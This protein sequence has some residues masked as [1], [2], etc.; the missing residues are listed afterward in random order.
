MT[1]DITLVK[2][3][4]EQTTP[5]DQTDMYQLLAAWNTS[6]E[7]ALEAGAIRV[8][9]M[10]HQYFEDVLSLTDATA[11]SSESE[12]H[13]EFLADCCEAYPSGTGDHFCSSILVNIVGRCVIQCRIKNGVEAIPPWALEYLTAVSTKNDGIKNELEASTVGWGIGHP[14]VAVGQKTI[15]RAAAGENDWAMAVLE[16]AVYADPDAGISL[17]EQL[18]REPEVDRP[19]QFL[20]PLDMGWQQSRP[21]LPDFWE[22]ADSYEWEIEFSQTQRN[23]ILDILRDVVPA[24]R[25]R[26]ADHAFTF[27]LK[28]VAETME[29]DQFPESVPDAMVHLG[30]HEGGKWHL[31]GDVGCPD[32]DYERVETVEPFFECQY[33][34]EDSLLGGTS[35]LT[36]RDPR[37][38]DLCRRCADT[39][40]DWERLRYQ[41]TATRDREYDG[42]TLV[43]WTPLTERRWA[44]AC[45][46]CQKP[47]GA[48]HIESTF[49][50]V[51]C[52]NCLRELSTA[53]G[54]QLPPSDQDRKTA[55]TLDDILSGEVETQV[56]PPREILEE[57]ANEQRRQ[58]NCQ[59]EHLPLEYTSLTQNKVEI[60]ADHGYE[61]VGDISASDPE[62]LAQ[63]DGLGRRWVPERLPHTYTLS[64]SAFDGIG[65]TLAARLEDHGYEMLPA[66]QDASANDL[67]EIKGM[68]H[69]KAE[70]II[71]TIDSW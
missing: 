48:T 58:H 19:L 49:D 56:L 26:E 70:T 62:S 9:V 7:A 50:Q 35:E 69:A 4:L 28:R 29:K 27:D 34:I 16:H 33:R 12:I 5:G 60:L 46:I 2:R 41:Y 43:T 61:T 40:S 63:I 17:F 54:L 3:A 55:L 59:R 30:K 51:A 6:I 37:G 45:G 10:M 14:T 42:G 68:S 57:R 8:E 44:R 52:P 24:T 20:E 47:A 39:V 31:L 67:A 18:V 11:R 36:S 21:P 64:L 15:N 25:L 22:S 1:R 53:G 65:S 66:L 71:E 32:G 38:L 23:Q 13:W